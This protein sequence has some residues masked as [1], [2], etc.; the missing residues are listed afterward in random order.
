MTVLIHSAQE[1]NKT[2]SKKVEDFWLASWS[3]LSNRISSPY[4]CKNSKIHSGL[5]FDL[6]S[7]LFSVEYV[8]TEGILNSSTSLFGWMDAVSVLLLSPASLTRWPANGNSSYSVG[9]SFIAYF[10]EPI[11]FTW[12]K[13]N[14]AVRHTFL[15]PWKTRSYLC[16]NR[17]QIL[18]L[19]GIKFISVMLLKI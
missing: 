18:L 15:H 17:Q 19:Q 1:I 4:C 11:F 7:F 3:K 13:I 14:F 6:I 16:Q 10:W 8:F 12:T 9:P 5:D 2:L